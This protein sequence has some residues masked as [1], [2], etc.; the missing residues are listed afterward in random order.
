MGDNYDRPRDPFDL[1]R[2]LV[3]KAFHPITYLWRLRGE[4]RRYRKLL[5]ILGLLGVIVSAQQWLSPRIT[6]RIIDDAYP[7][8]DFRLF[9]ILSAVLVGI[10][11][12][13]R[14]ISSVT[15]YLKLY[16]DNLISFKVRT[17]VFRALY[18]VP[19]SYVESH[20]S[21][22]FLERVARDANMTANMLSGLLPQVISLVLTL[23]ITLV[24]MIDI[25]PLVTLLVLAGVPPYYI[26]SSILALKMRAW[27]QVARFKEEEVTSKSVEA[28]QGVPT[29]RL[30]GVGTW[31]KKIYRKLLRDRIKIAFG[32][33]RTQL[34]YGLMNWVVTYGW[35][36][37]L[38]V[39]GW[40]LV[41]K[42]R[43]TLGDAVALGMYI[44]VL[45]RPTE[46]ALGIYR[47]LI[48]SSVPAQRVL[49]I[50][51]SAKKMHQEE[52]RS[53]IRVSKGIEFKN[54]N[55]SY[56]GSNWSLKDLS[57]NLKCGET[58][59][60][61]GPTGCG[62]T[63]FLRIM[64]G[65]YDDYTGDILVDGTSLRTVRSSAFQKNVAMVM[66]D[67]F[68]F[69]GTIMEN[70]CIAGP[71]VDADRVLST[72]EIL[73]L[74]EW[75]ETLPKGYDTLLGVGG[76]RLSS[77]QT[78]K[79]AILRAVLK[80]P[81]IYLMD[82]ITSAMDVASE[83]KILDG[84][85]KLKSPEAITVFTAHRLALTLEPDVGTVAVLDDGTLVECG[86]PRELYRR[87]GHYRRLM[88][89]SKLE[90]LF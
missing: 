86:V 9:Y 54:L 80:Q 39:G 61:I 64:A 79:L 90:A 33:W 49:E 38:T 17:R 78:Q 25:S 71:D 56:P 4:A 53:I 60:L 50:L 32:M 23:V 15:S 7:G 36:V 63:T 77:G 12:L 46:Q 47:S 58:L 42:D 74:N 73:G 29:A 83:R 52:K 19:I 30:F 31:L 81:T 62:K 82:E 14:I 43:L 40:Y 10:N 51:D 11:V 75:L 84:L 35:G 70:M 69:S 16:V 18:L 8:R 1:P 5:I 59:A 45:L 67:N 85:Y 66:A 44:P 26:I 6:R 65:L 88:D 72:A 27:S 76:I 57:L 41:F 2:F 20:Q 34:T 48:A 21:G 22:M 87:G 13:S 89:L 68:F 28:I 24:M 3:H 37:F 55:F